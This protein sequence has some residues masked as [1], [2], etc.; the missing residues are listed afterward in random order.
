MEI[1][2]VRATVGDAAHIKVFEIAEHGGPAYVLG[3]WIE[4][5]SDACAKDGFE[6]EHITLTRTEK[7]VPSIG[8]WPMS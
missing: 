5:M 7:T 2:V 1:P 3:C 4:D 8:C 6:I